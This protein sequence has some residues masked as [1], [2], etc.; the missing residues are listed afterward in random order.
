[1]KIKQTNKHTYIEY[2]SQIQPGI[3]EIQKE[4]YVNR[5][6][7]EYSNIDGVVLTN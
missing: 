1:M 5:Q 4:K 7:N 3:F 6:Q 2:S